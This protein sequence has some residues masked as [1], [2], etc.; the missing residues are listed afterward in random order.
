MPEPRKAV[1]QTALDNG[2]RVQNYIAKRT[3]ADRKNEKQKEDNT[4]V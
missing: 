4:Y 2:I 3:M 1:K